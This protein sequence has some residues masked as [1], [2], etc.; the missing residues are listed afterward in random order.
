MNSHRS[1]LVEESNNLLN[2]LLSSPSSNKENYSYCG[3]IQ[4]FIQ[5]GF[6]DDHVLR[7]I[8]LTKALDYLVIFPRTSN[9]IKANTH[10]TDHNR[11]EE[12]RG[13]SDFSLQEKSL[14]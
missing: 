10:V 6:S 2:L 4:K 1:A 3:T 7:L 11:G 12:P 8:E 9:Y 5:S 14:W 13:V